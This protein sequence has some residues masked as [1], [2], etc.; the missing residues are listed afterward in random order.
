MSSPTRQGGPRD[1]PLLGQELGKKA[2]QK[3]KARR[4]DLCTHSPPALQGWP[5][6]KRSQE[7]TERPVSKLLL[8]K[9]SQSGAPQTPWVFLKFPLTGH[10]AFTLFCRH[11]PSMPFPQDLCTCF[12]LCQKESS[13]R[14]SHD[15]ALINSRSPFK[16]KITLSEKASLTTLFKSAFFSSPPWMCFLNCI[17][18]TDTLSI[19]FFVYF[20]FFR[21]RGS[22]ALF[23]A[24]SPVPAAG[25]AQR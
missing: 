22:L 8:H 10:P 25:M 15:S 24:P 20:L 21:W 1:Q 4:P 17:C 12:P 14:Y 6:S 16:S 7:G 9:G 23:A 3:E 2:G 5:P 13:S 18:H 11:A 19:S